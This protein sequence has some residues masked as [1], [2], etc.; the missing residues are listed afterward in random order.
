MAPKG[1]GC[2]CAIPPPPPSPRDISPCHLSYSHAPSSPP[3]LWPYPVYVSVCARAD[4]I[5]YLRVPGS[6]RSISLLPRAAMGQVAEI[7]K[8]HGRHAGGA[9]A[10]DDRRV[11]A[12]TEIGGEVRQG[13]TTVAA[14]FQ[15][16]AAL[17]FS[18]SLSLSLTL[19][20]Y[21]FLFSL[22]ASEGEGGGSSSPLKSVPQ[23]FLH[24]L[25]TS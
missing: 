21:L 13:S 12:W 3:L 14:R 23:V 18:L 9:Q 7:Y 19:W 24:L 1:R 5:E 20:L 8:E 17:S 25:S 22:L 15:N 16:D 4:G 2:H 10:H 11:C 6:R